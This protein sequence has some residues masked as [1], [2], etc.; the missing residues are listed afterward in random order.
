MRGLP[1]AVSLRQI[2]SDCG[3]K[4]QARATACACPVAVAHPVVHNSNKQSPR[5]SCPTG[6]AVMASSGMTS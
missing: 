3:L 4:P 2:I 5:A 1:L 6:S